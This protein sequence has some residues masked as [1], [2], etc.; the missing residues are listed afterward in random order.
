[1]TTFQILLILC[2]GVMWGTLGHP[3]R[4]EVEAEGPYTHKHEP[5]GRGGEGGRA[6][7]N[8]LPTSL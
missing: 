5:E 8:T 2:V 6:N 4:C 3:R 7:F 1:M